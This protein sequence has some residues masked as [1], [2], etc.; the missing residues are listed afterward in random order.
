MEQIVESPNDH[1]PIISGVM[2][3]NELGWSSLDEDGIIHI[4]ASWGFANGSHGKTVCDEWALTDNLDYSTI[5]RKPYRHIPSSLGKET[6]IANELALQDI[7]SLSERQLTRLKRFAKNVESIFGKSMN[8]EFVIKEEDLYIVQIRPV[9][10]SYLSRD[11]SYLEPDKIPP[12]VKIFTGEMIISG[13]NQVEKLER[14]QITYAKNLEEAEGLFQPDH[15]K[16][17]IVYNYESSTTHY[18]VNFA[19]YHPPIPGLVLPYDK[20]L[21]GKNVDDRAPY[22]LCTQSGSLVEANG[23]ILSI[24]KGLFLHPARLTLS[25]CAKGPSIQAKSAHP[26]VVKLQNLLATTSEVLKERLDEIQKILDQIFSD[27]TTRTVTK[28]MLS[29]I[30]DLKEFSNAIMRQMQTAASKNHMTQL[31]FHAGMLR[32][33]VS[34]SG[35][36][37]LNAHSIS[38][39]E[40]ATNLPI[41]IR[42]FIGDHSGNQLICELALFGQN[43]FDETIQRRWVEFLNTNTQSNLLDRLNRELELQISL[44]FATSWLSE[45]FSNN[46]L[47]T[48]EILVSK[49]ETDNRMNRDLADITSEIAE[50]SDKLTSNQI[51]S[52]QELE[53]LWEHLEKISNDIVAHFLKNG[54]KHPLIITLIDLWDLSTKAAKTLHVYEEKESERV[55]KKRNDAFSQFAIAV[56]KTNLLNYSLE[57]FI[58]RDMNDLGSTKN[59]FSVQHWI[60]PVSPGALGRIQNEDERLTV[61]HQNL[62]QAASNANRNCLPSSLAF[63]YENFNRKARAER[64]GDNSQDY[65]SINNQQASVRINI[66]LNLHSTV[67]TLTQKKGCD[68]IEVMVYMRGSDNYR[69]QHLNIFKIFGE[70]ADIPLMDYHIFQTDLKVVFSV[71]EKEKIKLLGKA[72]YTIN[73]STIRNSGTRN[74][75]ILISI[76]IENSTV[77]LRKKR[78][79]ANDVEIIDKIASYLWNHL[80][81]TNQLL[82]GFSH[83]EAIE[84]IWDFLEK[85]KQLDKISNKLLA[86]IEGREPKSDF[87][88]FKIR[89]LKILPIDVSKKIIWEELTTGY[90]MWEEIPE[91]MREG[92]AGQLFYKAPEVAI[93]YCEE[94]EYLNC[95]ISLMDKKLDESEIHET[96][97][98]RLFTQLAQNYKSEEMPKKWAQE[99]ERLR[100]QHL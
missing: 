56:S 99:L 25:I 50:I 75:N 23:S 63:A 44:G 3:T 11:T 51:H 90:L 53:E 24:Q 88:H 7:P 78:L 52:K 28:K 29:I 55:F 96:H 30:S 98:I 85:H 48:I 68:A 76:F 62:L 8:V 77:L 4:T 93:K 92:F 46:V 66:P 59:K 65:I 36:Q 39:L 91:T 58:K 32:Q 31:A 40:V 16:A 1:L 97:E 20:W 5:R 45:N 22:L 89:A 27:L 49:I 57:D 95:F 74:F 15:S 19:S 13:S 87:G 17:V 10:S 9:Q 82:E 41:Y 35:K 69:S 94:E 14:S 73:S 81:R 71:K 18:A 42:E 84:C 47:P 100:N 38:G 2:L 6:K 72:V 54:N 26:A 34:Q 70:I 67:V 43:G 33:L 61:L 79:N 60:I 12:T 83:D 86:E 64:F 80:E 21:E 37:A